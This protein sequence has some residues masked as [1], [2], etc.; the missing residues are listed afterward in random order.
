V[1]SLDPNRQV[2]GQSAHIVANRDR[3]KARQRD[4]RASLKL[5]YD[6]LWRTTAMLHCF[7][8]PVIFLS[9]RG[10]KQSFGV[11]ADHAHACKPTLPD[12]LGK[13]KIEFNASTGLPPVSPLCRG[14]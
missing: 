3:Y 13:L 1:E 12:G 4:F 5:R 9:N 10:D 6:R 2:I 14:L 7:S 11:S 8:K